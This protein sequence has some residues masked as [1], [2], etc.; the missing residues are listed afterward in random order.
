VGE[1]IRFWDHW[2][3]GVDTGL[4]DEPPLRFWLQDS[5]PPAGT[6]AER[7]GRWVEESSWP[8][9]NVSDSVLWLNDGTLDA[10]ATDGAPLSVCSPQTFG[11]AGGDMCS[12]AI[13]GDLPIDCRIDAGGALVFRGAPLVEP[14]GHSRSA[15]TVPEALR[16]PTQGF[17]AVLLVDEAPD[18]AQTL[19]SRG[20]CNLTHRE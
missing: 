6:Q 1:V 12:F 7:P 3:K 18:G 14:S 19:I 16:G 13:P 4:M 9:P 15:R 10:T 11:S 8:S 2:L 5:V 17:V 20:F